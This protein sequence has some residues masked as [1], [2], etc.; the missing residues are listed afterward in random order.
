MV[1]WDD[2]DTQRWCWHSRTGRWRNLLDP[3][4]DAERSW[5]DRPRSF[6]LECYRYQVHLGRRSRL[7]A[8]SPWTICVPEMPHY[9]RRSSRTSPRNDRLV[10]NRKRSP[11]MLRV[12]R[13]RQHLEWLWTIRT[14]NAGEAATTFSFVAYRLPLLLVCFRGVRCQMAS[15]MSECGMVS[16]YG[17]RGTTNQCVRFGRLRKGRG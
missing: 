9:H 8:F 4:G 2:P 13:L 11:H 16:A 6:P 10:Y 7:G 15:F 17:R 3:P 5:L 1:E 12:M 14:W